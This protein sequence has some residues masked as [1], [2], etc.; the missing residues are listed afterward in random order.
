MRL[1]LTAPK[2]VSGKK[3]AN[4]IS[5][6]YIEF[7]AL[8]PIE[9]YKYISDGNFH[10]ICVDHKQVKEKVFAPKSNSHKYYVKGSDANI[11]SYEP[12]LSQDSTFEPL[13]VKCWLPNSNLIKNC[14]ESITHSAYFDF[15]EVRKHTLPRNHT[16][17]PDIG[18]WIIGYNSTVQEEK[19]RRRMWERQLLLESKLFEKARLFLP[20]SEHEHYFLD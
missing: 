20:P 15:I 1:T 17:L 10:M 19:E 9:D 11:D 6:D 4:R 14:L 12:F 16:L 13:L 7:A 8:L 2:Q 5:K 3:V 18:K